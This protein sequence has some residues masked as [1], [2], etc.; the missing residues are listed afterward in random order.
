[1]KKTLITAA[2]AASFAAAA[3]ADGTAVTLPELT[4][5]KTNITGAL[6]VTGE[7]L[8]AVSGGKQTFTLVAVFDYDTL[9]KAVTS[10]DYTK[11]LTLWNSGSYYRSIAVRDSNDGSTLVFD[12]FSGTSHEGGGGLSF[13][14]TAG[15]KIVV[16]LRQDAG[17]DGVLQLTTYNTTTETMVQHSWLKGAGAS[18]EFTKLTS[19]A[20]Y[21]LEAVYVYGASLDGDQRLAA[22]KAAYTAAKPVP[23]PTTA[24]LSLLALA[25]LAARR[26]RK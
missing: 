6:N 9:D 3:Y 7:H 17:T 2:L 12:G 13:T 16:V 25:G 26:R 11:I 23:E 21:G 24:T 8:S 4:Y 1:M 14:P 15:E 22:A 10:N 5:S 18:M 20:G 19:E